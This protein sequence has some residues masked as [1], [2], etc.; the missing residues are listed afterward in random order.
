MEKYQGAIFIVAVCAIVLLILAV[1]SN[2]EII[3]NFVYRCVGGT[4]LIF[5]IN[6][7]VLFL[8]FSATIGIN[9]ITVLTS[10]ILGFP[11]IILLFG[12]RIY[13]IL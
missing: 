13:G 6:Q 10:G 3:L 5:L 7:T 2:S 11:G 4:I 12:I 8:G 1:K 9:F